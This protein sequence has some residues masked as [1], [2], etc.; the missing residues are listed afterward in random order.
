MTTIFDT[1]NAKFSFSIE[2]PETEC[3]KGA[4]AVCK[5][6]KFIVLVTDANLDAWHTEGDRKDF[7]QGVV[8]M[9]CQLYCVGYASNAFKKKD[10]TFYK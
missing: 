7:F 5:N 3:A 6:D 1:G 10:Y 9:T 2:T 4:F 8:V